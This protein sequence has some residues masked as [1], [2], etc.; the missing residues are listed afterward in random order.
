[1]AA[2]Y[3]RK[4]SLDRIKPIVEKLVAAPGFSGG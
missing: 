2:R 4:P 1:M 3:G